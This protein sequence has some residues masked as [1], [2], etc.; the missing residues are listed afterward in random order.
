[1]SNEGDLIAGRYRLVERIG[2]GSMGS[3]WRGADEVLRRAVAVKLLL[4]RA[5]VTGE[6][7][8]EAHE[9]AR[10]EARITARLHHPNAVTVYDVV[11]HQGTPVLVMEYVPA[12][13]LAAVLAEHGPLPPARVAAIGAQIAAALTAAHRVGIVH[14]DIKPGN[15]LLPE[16]GSAK[17]VDF[18]ISRAVGD[19]VITQT[20]LVSGTPAYLAPEVAGGAAPTPAS[21]VFALG[22]TLYAAVEGEPPFAG[23]NAL[24]VLYSAA[25]GRVRPPRRAGPLTPV[26][27]GL[28]QPEPAARLTLGEASARLESLAQQAMPKPRKSTVDRTAMVGAGPRRTGATGTL[29]AA[30]AFPAPLPAPA[31]PVRKRR[32]A[33]KAIVFTAAAAAIVVGV[34]LAVASMSGGPQTAQA[35]GS[36]STSSTTV[37]APSPAGQA[38]DATAIKR[39][40]VDYYGLLP[41]NTQA[42]FR[43]LSPNYQ[44][45]NGGFGVFQGFYRTIAAVRVRE[46]TVIDSH[47]A[48]AIL[49]FAKKGGGT[50][51][52]TYRFALI[53]SNGHLLIDNAVLVSSAAG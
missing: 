36:T 28:L 37:T 34:A 6:A 29:S 35:A 51:T 25:A 13:S 40:L 50:S 3:V 18:G 33:T 48:T 30:N 24:A 31:R 43:E 5:D 46:V 16:G 23:E 27:T 39:F 9:R 38:P 21:D 14:R 52:E 22:A 41:H 15:V 45:Q 17:L 49:V 42:A 7:L 26:L 4:E 12:P 2:G 11:D 8:E 44:R 20:G 1:M 32:R 47:T 53:T 10:R 19:V